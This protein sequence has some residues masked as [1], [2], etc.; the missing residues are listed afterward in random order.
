MNLAFADRDFYYGDPHF[1]PS[2]PIKGLL[3]K[4]YAKQR[5]KQINQDRNNPFVGPGD[6][7]PFEGK[8]NPFT[9]LLKQR[10]GSLFDRLYECIGDYYS[11]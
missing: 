1:S 3:N 10:E 11:P 4:E 7:Y 6:P 9:A 2:S 8:T 5:A